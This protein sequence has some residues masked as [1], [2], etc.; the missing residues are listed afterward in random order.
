MG[1][2]ELGQIKVLLVDDQSSRWWA[3]PPTDAPACKW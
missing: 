2:A 3:R 1:D